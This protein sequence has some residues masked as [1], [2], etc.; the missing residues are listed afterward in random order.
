MENAFF[1]ALTSLIWGSTWL[2]ITFQLGVVAP[3]ASIV[4]RFA[5]AAIVLMVYVALRRLPMRFSARQH[6]QIALQG[7][8]LFSLNYI[9]VYLAE[10]HLTSGL[11]AIVF[12]MLILSN[13]LLGAIFLRNPIRPRVVLGGVIGVLG[14]ALVFWP[15]LGAF[16]HNG[17][18]Q[19]GLALS[20]GAVLCASIGNIVSAGNQ[21]A[22]LPIV[23]SNAYGMAYGALATLVIALLRGVPFTFEPTTGYV[24]SLLYL[25]VFGSVVA[26][27]TYLTLIGRLGVDRAAYIGVIFPL[28][29]ILLSTLFE[30]LSLGTLGLAGVALVVAGN[31][32][33]L[34]RRRAAAPVAPAT[35]AA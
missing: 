9:L 32:L 1:Y 14:L 19:L 12:S 28:V 35:P 3:E 29:A 25:A 16:A 4:Y 21:R 30:G 13:I 23:Q 5:L 27:G 7:L 10:Q 31:V 17:N 2:A 26:F 11:V 6:G 20:V 15:E 22:G 33:V 24:L 34:N 8:F 18:W